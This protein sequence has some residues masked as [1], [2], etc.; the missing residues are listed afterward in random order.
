MPLAT[1]TSK[2][3]ITIPLAVRQILGLNAGDKLEFIIGKNGEVTFKPVAG[4]VDDVFGKLHKPERKPVSVEAMNDA[5][6]RK[7]KERSQ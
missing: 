3:Q 4:R 2:G 6:R 5:V 7:L 1:L